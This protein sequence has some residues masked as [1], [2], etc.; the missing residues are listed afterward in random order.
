MKLSPQRLKM[1]V[2]S[3]AEGN[4]LT[5]TVEDGYSVAR[6]DTLADTGNGNVE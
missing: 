3:G 2:P 5:L 4:A 6:I 1:I